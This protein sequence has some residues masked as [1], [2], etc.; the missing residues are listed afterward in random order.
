M[1]DQ[2]KT[3]LQTYYSDLVKQM[4]DWARKN[5]Q[6]GEP[7]P[8]TWCDAIRLECEQMNREAKPI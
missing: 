1:K 8:E 6:I 3:L 5:Y 4:K 2:N 7:I